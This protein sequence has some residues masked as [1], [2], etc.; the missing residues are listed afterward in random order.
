MTK[1]MKLVVVGGVAGGMSCAARARRLSE[2]SDIIV[3]ERG[4]Y[5]SFANCGLPYFLGGTITERK[6]LTG[7][8]VDHLRRTMNLD[9]RTMSEVVSIDR[10]GKSVKIR[11]LESGREYE[12]S[13]DALLLAT[14]SAPIRPPIPGIDRA[15]IFT[16]RNVPDMDLID[17]WIRDHGAKRAVIGGGGYIGL[18]V[19]EQLRERGLDVALAEFGPQVMAPLDPEMAGLLHAEL[20]AH[21]VELHLSDPLAALEDGDGD[22]MTVVLGSGTRLA[23]DIVVMGLGVKPE[24]GLAR[25]AGLEIGER[26]GVR[27][28][29]SLRTSDPAIFAVGD[30]IE[31]RDRISGAW[32]LIPLAGPANRQGRIAADNM[33]GGSSVYAATQGTAVLKL[34]S[35]TAGCTGANEKSLRAA[36]RDYRVVHLHPNSHA[37]YYPGASP[38]ALKLIYEPYTGMVLGAQAVGKDGVDKRIDV[39]A[40]AIAAGMSVDDLAELELSYAPPYGS[41][42]DPVN[43]AGMVAQNVENGL[44]AMATWDQVDALDRGT[45][46]LLDVREHDEVAK[47]IIEGAMHIP[48]GELRGRLSEIPHGREVVVYCQSGQRSYNAARILAQNGF[49]VRNLSGAYKTWKAAPRETES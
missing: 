21:G 31:V 9:V 20:R 19:A 36:K 11:D 45:I 24:V 38:I 34:F 13:Y 41:A 17:A 18:E 16:L 8:T 28:D 47:G 35:L 37:G 29:P 22:G 1:P 48:L 25:E 32:S 2:A 15:G 7:H 12:E 44:V 40:T 3:L 10:V 46:A 43:L 27:V 42:K 4:P 33:Y 23:A 14:G 49:R 39:I 5:P 6:K 26:G 30:M